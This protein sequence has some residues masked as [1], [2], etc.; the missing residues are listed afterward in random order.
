MCFDAQGNEIPEAGPAVIMFKLFYLNYCTITST[1]SFICKS[2]IVQ[3]GQV[4]AR[5]NYDESQ[6]VVNGS[7]HCC[8]VPVGTRLCFGCFVSYC[9][10]AHTAYLAESAK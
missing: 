9:D 10:K 5:K 2:C 8:R 1:K 3:L 6:R 7:R 4:E